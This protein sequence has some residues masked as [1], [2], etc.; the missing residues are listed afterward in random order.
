[1]R[2]PALGAMEES[3]GH[4]PGRL[5]PLIE[6]TFRL[7]FFL[8]SKT[9]DEM[10]E[11]SERK[12]VDELIALTRHAQAETRGRRFGLNSSRWRWVRRQSYSNRYAGEYPKNCFIYVRWVTEG[13]IL[14]MA[15][16]LS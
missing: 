12:A 15:L 7:A 11:A 1:M 2:F 14:G 4:L 13:E 9:C 6:H 5:A 8:A 16:H 10:I 3:N